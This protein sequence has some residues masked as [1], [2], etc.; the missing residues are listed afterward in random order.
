MKFKF[1]VSIFL[2]AFCLSN[3]QENDVLFTV[4]D[5]PVTS[6]EFKRVYNKN[7][8]LVKDENQKDVD[9]YLELYIKYKLK[10]EE[11]KALKLDQDKQY[12]N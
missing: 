1:I 6:K 2:A 3:A 12:I 11:A 5:T 8:D 7:I 4:N 10:L 9:E